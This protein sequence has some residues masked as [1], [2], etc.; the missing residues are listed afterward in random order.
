MSG[1]THSRLGS[2]GG[3][4]ISI[5]VLGTVRALLVGDARD[6]DGLLSAA[7]A[8]RRKG[9]R[10]PAFLWA[11]LSGRSCSPCPKPHLE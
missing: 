5:L 7:A 2:P 8:P 10:G 11:A 3:L 6:A 9:T 4:V 1:R